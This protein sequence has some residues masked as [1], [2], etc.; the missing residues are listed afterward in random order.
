[1]MSMPARSVCVEDQDIRDV[2]RDSLRDSYGMVLQETW[3]KAGTIR[4]NIR[5]GKT[6]C[7][8]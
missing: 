7:H 8:R 3:L 1:M 2:T 4:E 6:G 5:N